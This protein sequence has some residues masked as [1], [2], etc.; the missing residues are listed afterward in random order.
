MRKEKYIKVK[1]YKGNTYFTVQFSY[2]NK[3]DKH[4]YSKSFNSADY[5]SPAQALNEACRHRDIK[6]AELL[7]SGLPTNKMTVLEAYEKSKGIFKRAEST[8]TVM[9]GYFKRYFTE[10]ENMPMKDV[11][12]FTI[13]AHL[14]SIRVNKSDLVLAK[15]LNMWRRICKTAKGLKAITSNPADAVEAPRSAIQVEPRKQAFTDEEVN[16]VVNRL[17]TP[18]PNEGWTYNRYILSVMIVMARFTGLRPRE[19]KYL[20]REDV[21]FAND[22]VFVKPH[23][24]NIKTRASIRTVPLNSVVKSELLTLFSI[25]PYE[26]PFSFYGGIIPEP[27][28]IARTM[29]NASIE[30]GV[31]GFH[32]YGMRHS[33]DSELITNGVDP[34]TVMELMGHNNVNTTL[35][36]YARSTEEKRKEAIQRVEESRKPS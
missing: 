33:F 30:A 26:L 22:T 7:T 34:R 19:I 24:K 10:Y 16:A 25:S 5:D 8:D 18:T 4:T 14:E 27:N 13:L 20:E 6:R 17:R 9:D 3:W 23:G 35:A 31:P 11:D 29:R 1:T 32:L 2:G 36:I 21:D 28:A 15:V 12:E